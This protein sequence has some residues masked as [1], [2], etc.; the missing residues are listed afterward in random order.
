MEA[1]LRQVGN[2]LGFTLPASQLKELNARSGDVI[3]L[4]IKRV[5][6][7]V[8][9]GWSNADSWAGAAEESAVIEHT[10]FDRE[11]WQW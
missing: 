10:D 11:D 4:E 5:V 7:H 2:S 3:E 9:A 1:K 6:R 8:R